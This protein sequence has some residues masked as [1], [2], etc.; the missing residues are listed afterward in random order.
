MAARS[1]KADKEPGT[2]KRMHQQSQVM[3]KPGSGTMHKLEARVEGDRTG[4]RTRDKVS[5]Y[6]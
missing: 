6:T 3:D 5:A 2:C 4:D 1:C